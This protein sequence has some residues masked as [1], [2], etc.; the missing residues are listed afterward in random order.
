VAEPS[1]VD[2]LGDPPEDT[3][4]DTVD[5]L[6]EESSDLDMIEKLIKWL[7]GGGG[8]EG[9]GGG[10]GGMEEEEEEEGEGGRGG[11]GGAAVAD[12]LFSLEQTQLAQAWISEVAAD[13][14]WQD[15]CVF[16]WGGGSL[17]VRVEELEKLE[18]LEAAQSEKESSSERAAS[19]RSR[20]RS[21][22]GKSDH[23]SSSPPTSTSLRGGE[24]EG[25]GDG[26]EGGG[27]G[28]TGAGAGA[29][30]GGGERS[31]D[32]TDFLSSSPRSP[33]IGPAGSSFG[34]SGFS[35]STP[36]TF[37]LNPNNFKGGPA[38]IETSAKLL[39]SKLFQGADV[40]RLY[41]DRARYDAK[42]FGDH[43]EWS[44]TGPDELDSDPLPP[45]L[46]VIPTSYT[47][48]YASLGA[49][50]PPGQEQTAIC[51]VCGCILDAQGKGRCTQHSSVC[52]G[53]VGVFFLM[54]DCKGLLVHN[55]KAAYVQSPY[56]DSHGE[57]PQF[58]GR[59]LFLDK[60]RLKV[61]EELWTSH[62]ARMKVIGERRSQRQVR[63]YKGRWDTALCSMFCSTR[64]APCP[65]LRRSAN[66]RGDGRSR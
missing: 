4:E 20:S 1:L 60:D 25:E 40:T 22:S 2:G 15:V 24:G 18:K 37:L 52:G 54:Q 62:G 41:L 59:P 34:A 8:G 30:A 21:S 63:Q 51:L 56:V 6:M 35:P 65:S 42:I 57:T 55:G 38:S 5:G 16:G 3:N 66:S 64:P 7:G 29:G 47:D 10:G 26:G 19:S 9:G 58:R 28:G 53:G 11:G 61:F 27:G 39:G 50:C 33:L 46:L 45:R 32:S 12:D 36:S 44:K 48:L 49:L 17:D 23:F 13:S 43:D 31:G 14:A